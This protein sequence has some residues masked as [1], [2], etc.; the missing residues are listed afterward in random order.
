MTRATV[1]GGA[2]SRVAFVVAVAAL[3]VGLVGPA[4]AADPALV[5]TRVAVVLVNFRND[6]SR[7]FS[8][9]DASE[10]TFGGS[11]SVADLYRA[12]SSERLAVSGDAYGWLT[13]DRDNLPGCDVA[14][15]Q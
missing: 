9:A 12:V 13:V 6:Q 5:T 1:K 8:A 7:P 4:Q 10:W 14:G 11:P 2:R 15:W 3:A